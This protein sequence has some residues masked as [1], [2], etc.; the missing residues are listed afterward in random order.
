MKALLYL[1]EGWPCNMTLACDLQV[2]TLKVN[3]N[4]LMYV[5]AVFMYSFYLLF[6]SMSGC[7]HVHRLSGLPVPN[8][9]VPLAQTIPLGC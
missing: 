6:R 5:T 2:A 9:N 4:F 1:A 8:S 3:T 7:A